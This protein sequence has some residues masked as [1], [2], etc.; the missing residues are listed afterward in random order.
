MPASSVL[1]HK[2]LYRNRSAWSESII[3]MLP[4]QNGPNAHASFLHCMAM[5]SAIPHLLTDVFPNFLTESSL[6]NLMVLE[7]AKIFS[8][9]GS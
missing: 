3:P 1:A 9:Y 6:E 8:D 5:F 2:N 4:L 7:T